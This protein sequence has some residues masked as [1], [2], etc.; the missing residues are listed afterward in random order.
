MAWYCAAQQAGPASWPRQSSPSSRQE[1]SG[2]R[3]VRELD[4]VDSMLFIIRGSLESITT[5]GG[6]SGFFN[7]SMLQE[8]DFC[9]EELL[10]WALDPKAAAN[11]PLSTRSVKAIS[12]V[13]GFA[14]H[15]D[16]LKFVAGQFRRLHSKQLQ[17]TFRFY[18][19]QWRTWA[20]SF[21]QATWRRYQKRK[22][23]EQR[24]REVEQMY[25]MASTSSSGHFKTTFLVSRF[26]KKAMRNV[27]RKRL[28]REES[29]IL[30]PK[31]PEPDFGRMHY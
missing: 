13:E 2:T 21:I 26:A 15:A 20:S 29:L 22:R 4:P 8:S 6:R 10:T 7:R 31:P 25:G 3:L 16:E 12:E 27:L 11:L 24:R 23:L 14:L 17:Q 5:D 18:S 1:D 30:L 9:G 28:L 19:Q